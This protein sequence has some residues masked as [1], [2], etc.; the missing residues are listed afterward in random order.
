[1]IALPNAFRKYSWLHLAPEVNKSANFRGIIISSRWK[2]VYQISR[3]VRT[4]AEHLG[5]LATVGSAVLSSVDEIEE[6]WKSSA[7]AAQKA[8]QLSTQLSS[9]ALRV[10][11]GTLVIPETQAILSV[12]STTCSAVSRLASRQKDNLA[13]V[14]QSIDD[15]QNDIT[16]KFLH[17]TDGN[18]LYHFVDLTVNPWVWKQVSRFW[19]REIR[20]EL[21]LQPG[22]VPLEFPHASSPAKGWRVARFVR[23]SILRR[24]NV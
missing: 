23:W 8:A 20:G 7:P 17:F 14:K 2:S 18:T 24:W 6:V 1:V 11:T 19:T 13:T 3:K 10:I 16:A 12:L 15:Y 4:Y 9:M 22:L 21:R 5:T